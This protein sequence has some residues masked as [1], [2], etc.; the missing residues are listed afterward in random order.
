MRVIMI[1]RHGWVDIDK[2]PVEPNEP[3]EVVPWPDGGAEG[4]RTPS[5]T[6]W[7]VCR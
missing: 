7:W 2:D 5:L 3:M 6:L 1:A 4:V